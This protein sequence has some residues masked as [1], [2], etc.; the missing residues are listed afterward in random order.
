MNRVVLSLGVSG[1]HGFLAFE[2]FLLTL[3]ASALLKL[4]PLLGLACLL[5]LE[6]GSFLLLPGFA[7]PSLQFGLFRLCLLLLLSLGSQQFSCLLPFLFGCLQSR[8]NSSRDL[9]FFPLL[10]FSLSLLIA[11]GFRGNHFIE[12]SLELNQLLFL[13]DISN[14]RVLQCSIHY[15]M[16]PIG[17]VLLHGLPTSPSSLRSLELSVVKPHRFRHH[18][19]T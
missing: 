12:S 2:L 6:L 15:K 17:D 11:P 14:C 16:V 7:L 8:S 5:F 4:S 1:G 18:A 9:R 13:V 10:K 3:D 19:T